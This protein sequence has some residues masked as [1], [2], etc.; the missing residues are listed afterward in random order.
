MTIEE[1]IKESGT[2]NI[3]A[4]GST[5]KAQSLIE[6]NE[7]ILYAINANVTIKENKSANASAAI[8]LKNTVKNAL[9]GVVAVTNKRILFCSSILG[10]STIKQILVRDITSVDEDMNGLLQMGQM[11]IQGITEHFIININKK[12]VAEELRRNIYKSQEMQ[13]EKNAMNTNNSNTSSNADEIL[14]FKKLL[15]EGIITQEEFER[16]KQDL[17]NS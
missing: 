14:K 10:K 8:S 7:E 5:K 12:K 17:L 2:T 3:L 15:D 16:K 9:N 6:N 1:A 13:K 4:K 11:R